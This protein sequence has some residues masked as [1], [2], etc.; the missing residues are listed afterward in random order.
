MHDRDI[1][2]AHVVHY[3]LSHLRFDA[4]I[5]EE[6][7]VAALESRFHAAGE[8]DHDGRGGVGR[9]GEA[10]PEHESGR[11]HEGEVEDLRGHL[12]RLEAGE[13]GEHCGGCGGVVVMVVVFGG[14][15]VR[16][17]WVIG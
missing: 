14:G 4:A 2:A 13:G 1:L 7:Q 10:F 6:E 11:E 17:W 12:A 16:G 5:P 8:D 9:D 15:G 3:D